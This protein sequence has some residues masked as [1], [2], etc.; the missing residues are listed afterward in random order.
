VKLYIYTH[1]H[2]QYKCR[3]VYFPEVIR[4]ITVVVSYL[5][6]YQRGSG[7][8]MPEHTLDYVTPFSPCWLRT[9]TKVKLLCWQSRGYRGRVDLGNVHIL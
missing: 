8:N 9:V 4:P 1:T 6:L 5:K 7:L 3:V 2:T